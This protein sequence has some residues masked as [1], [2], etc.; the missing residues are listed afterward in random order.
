MGDVVGHGIPAA[1][2]MAQLR[3]ALRA[4]VWDGLEPAE[5]LSR[6]NQFLYGLEREGMASASLGLLDPIKNTLRIANAGHPPFLRLTEDGSTE[7]IGE[8]LGPP[9]GAIPFATY[10]EEVLDLKSGDT[11]VFYTDGL[12]EDRLS[13]LDD[14]LDLMR[15]AAS[16]PHK[17]VD[18]LCDSI[19]AACIGGRTA[20][21]DV[22]VLVLR[23]LQMGATLSLRLPAEPRVLSSL[24]QTI[25]RWLREQGIADDEVHEVL[26]AT[27]EACNNAIEHG[28]APLGG[29]FEIEAV[30]DGDL[31]VVVRSAGDWRPARDDKGGRGLPVIESL[32]DEVKIERGADGVEV[33]MR[34]KM[35]T[36]NPIA[37]SRS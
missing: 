24:R 30:M 28:A 27:G 9:L 31:N 29:W 5:V 6:L 1:S 13:P 21:D 19:L 3:N 37:G 36:R 14:G 20:E 26:V 17:S 10:R 4:Y 22:A 32:M 12:V 16:A 15:E 33:R 23:A 2:L 8:G 18:A 25:R 7:F 34:R 11:L 35:N